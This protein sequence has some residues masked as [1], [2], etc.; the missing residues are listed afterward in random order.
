MPLETYRCHACNKK[1]FEGNLAL[2]VK[3]RYQEPGE[4]PYIEV[5]C[6]RCKHLNRYT[7]DPSS[8][9]AK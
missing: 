9:V 3:K 6:H 7:Y 5:L 2:L 4:Q 8:Y 1:P